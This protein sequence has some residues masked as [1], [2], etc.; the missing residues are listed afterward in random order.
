MGKQEIVNFVDCETNERGFLGVRVA[1]NVVGLAVSLERD[2]DIEVFLDG[3][4]V[5]LV[6]SAIERARSELDD[7]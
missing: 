3:E 6:A 4:T 2:G 7:D 5:A 1:G